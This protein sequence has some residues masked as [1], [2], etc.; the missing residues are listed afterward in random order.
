MNEEAPM[1]SRWERDTAMGQ[2]R[3]ERCA[4]DGKVLEGYYKTKKSR[5]KMYII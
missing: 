1:F 5:A 2:I 4:N 3:H